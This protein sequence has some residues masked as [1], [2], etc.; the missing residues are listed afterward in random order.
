MLRHGKY[1]L[2][3]VHQDD[4]PM[5]LAWRNSDRISSEM[6]TT[7]KITWAEHEAWFKHIHQQKPPRNFVFCY[8][9]R[10]IGYMGFSDWDEKN[11]TCSSSS[12]IGAMLDVPIDA[13]LFVDYMGLEYIFSH[14]E[15][16][17]VW[18]Y[19]FE[20]N[21]RAY[22]LNLLLGYKDEGYLRQD[23]LQNGRLRDVHVIGILRSEWKQE[24]ERIDQLYG[25]AEA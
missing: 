7:H 4:L 21:K 1:S 19:V 10:A 22:K 25:G 16:N 11:R 18:S 23:F 14:T 13:G 15:M 8:E 12:Y 20:H 3:P 9:N 5:L 24:K 6:L 2:R 17:K